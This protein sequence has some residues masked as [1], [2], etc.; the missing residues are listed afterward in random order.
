MNQNLFA[1]IS[2]TEHLHK[3]QQKKKKKKRYIYMNV[4]A[5]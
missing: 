3:P 4:S 2:V 1:G 5:G